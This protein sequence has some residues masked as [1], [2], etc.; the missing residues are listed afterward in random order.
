MKLPDTFKGYHPPTSN[1]TYTPNQFFDV[2][3]PRSSRGVVR[4]IAYMIRKSLGW[5]DAHGSPQEPQ[6]V[7]SYREPIENAGIGRARIKEA[8]EEAIKSRYIVCLR[9]ARPNTLGYLGIS[10]LYE[11]R[12]DEREE[13]I[14]DSLS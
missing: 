12:W 7:V 14:T 10:A 3:L 13:Y 1:T 4:L 9:E 5:C 6:V 8:I 11:L 2:V